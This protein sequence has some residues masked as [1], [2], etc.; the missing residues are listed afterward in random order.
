[1]TS[2]VMK[3]DN[4]E[5][6]HHPL[7]ELEGAGIWHFC[8][9][10]GVTG[11]EPNLHVDYSPVLTHHIFWPCNMPQA[12]NIA[13]NGINDSRLFEKI[14]KTYVLVQIRWTRTLE[15]KPPIFKTFSRTVRKFRLHGPATKGTNCCTFYRNKS[16][17]GLTS[18]RTTVTSASIRA[19]NLCVCSRVQKWTPG[20]THKGCVMQRVSL[21]ALSD[22][23][24]VRGMI[25]SIVH[26]S[27][28][29]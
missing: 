10:S 16:I 15:R 26:Q 11:H 22:N 20:L 5:Y 4:A 3:V 18:T 6:S 14:A 13:I 7:L 25:Q 29:D 23:T 9:G 2:R 8:R 17:L 1:M 24:V 27:N 12:I 28:V 21:G 19:R